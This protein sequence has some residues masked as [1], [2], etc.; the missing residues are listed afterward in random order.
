MCRR[1]ILFADFVA[2]IEEEPQP[3]GVMFRE[4]VRGKG[5]SFGQKDWKGSLEHDLK[6]FGLKSEGWSEAAQKAGRW[7]R[8]VEDG[9]KTYVRN[10]RSCLLYT[11]DAAD[12]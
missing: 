6:E 5:Y 4:M 8:W 3:R 9:V 12:E 1:R 2:Y 7:L 10:R 11:S